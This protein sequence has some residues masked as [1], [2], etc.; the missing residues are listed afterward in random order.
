[1]AQITVVRRR[2]N[3]DVGETGVSGRGEH[4]VEEGPSGDRH[5]R[6]HAG[7]GGTL[8]V[9]GERDAGVCRLHPRAEPAGEDDRAGSHRARGSRVRGFAGSELAVFRG[10]KPLLFASVASEYPVFPTPRPR[11]PRT[12]DLSRT[13]T[14]RRTARFADRR[15]CRRSGRTCCR[16]RCCSRCSGCPSAPSWSR[17]RHRSGTRRSGC[18]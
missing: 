3:G 4:V 16:R 1:M 11:E 10:N 7:V 12:R 5:H 13:R 9:G 17:C 8:L 6:L 2:D 15:W 18:R 14:V